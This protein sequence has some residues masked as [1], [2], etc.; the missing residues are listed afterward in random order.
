MNDE[1]E[2]N[3]LNIYF[4][5][6]LPVYIFH[7]IL[8]LLYSMFNHLGIIFVVIMCVLWFSVGMITYREMR[9]WAKVV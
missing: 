3:I 2:F 6:L 5:T 1:P 8:E 4:G 7:Y 9:V